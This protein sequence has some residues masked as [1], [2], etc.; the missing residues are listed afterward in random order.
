MFFKI[1]KLKKKSTF[2]KKEL[3]NQNIMVRYNT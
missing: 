1:V 3:T 2:R